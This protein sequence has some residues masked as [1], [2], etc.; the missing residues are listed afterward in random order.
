MTYS[1]KKGMS[2]DD[3]WQSWQDNNPLDKIEATDKEQ[4]ETD[5]AALREV[6][7]GEDVEAI[8]SKIEA[9]TASSMKLGEAMYKAEQEAATAADGASPEDGMDGDAS[10][11]ADD[12][13]VVDADFEEVEDEKKDKSA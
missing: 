10:K 3:Q 7:G 8:K 9:L 1:W 4:V 5:I 6:M 2:I 12:P 11:A 13:K